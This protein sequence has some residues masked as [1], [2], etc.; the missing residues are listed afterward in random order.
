MK[1]IVKTDRDQLV[2]DFFEEVKINLDLQDPLRNPFSKSTIEYVKGPFQNDFI[3]L[4]LDSLYFVLAKYFILLVGFGVALGSVISGGFW[5]PWWYGLILCFG[6]I[7]LFF[8]SSWWFYFLFKAGLKKTGYSGAIKKWK[9]G[10][11]VL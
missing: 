6:M 9:E 4:T 7:Y 3:I 8:T 11:G 10:G 1:L 2:K 5:L